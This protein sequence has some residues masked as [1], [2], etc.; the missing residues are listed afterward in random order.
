MELLDFKGMDFQTV[1][2]RCVE[3]FRGGGVVMH[4][5]DTCYGLAADIRSREGVEKVYQIKKMSLLKPVSVLVSSVEMA[6]Q[7]G[8]FD[9]AAEGLV[10]RY[11]PGPLTLIVPRQSSLPDHLNPEAETIGMRWPQH[12]FAQAVVAELGA[13]IVTTSANITGN[14]E[15]YQVED[16]LGQLAENDLRPD[17]I[18][19][20]GKQKLAKPSTIVRV[21]DGEVEL[22]R[23]GDLILSQEVY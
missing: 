2:Q 16:F 8:L 1:V 18:I 12:E 19:D 7:Y 17:L 23:H 22:I 13:P 15:V 20:A 9:E 21:V 4:H 3:I 6:R 14:K 11:W 10:A 5:T